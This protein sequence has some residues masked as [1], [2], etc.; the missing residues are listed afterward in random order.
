MAVLL[1]ELIIVAAFILVAVGALAYVLVNLLLMAVHEGT[2][3]KFGGPLSA[4]ARKRWQHEPGDGLRARFTRIVWRKSIC[5]PSISKRA[6]RKIY[7]GRQ[8]GKL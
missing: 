2:K 1:W 4:R 8:A 7:V 6:A 5:S 3:R